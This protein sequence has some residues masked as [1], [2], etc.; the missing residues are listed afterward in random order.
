MT[1]EIVYQGELRTLMTHLN[2]GSQ[3]E[4]DAP[5][6]NQGK[7]ERFSP[8]DLVASALASCMLTVMGIAAK[9]HQIKLDGIRMQVEKVMVSDPLRR[10][11]AIRIIF[12]NPLQINFSDKE[13]LI[14]EKAALTCPVYLSLSDSVEKTVQWYW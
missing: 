11:G 2:S 3:V 8:T 1:A 13:R 14:L 5:K 12:S 4:T 9:V 6:D 7:G 10:I